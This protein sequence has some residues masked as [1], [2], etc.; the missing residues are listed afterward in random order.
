MYSETL[1]DHFKNPRNAGELE[2]ANVKVE[3]SNLVCGDILHLTAIV[4]E[5]SI[6]E[7]RFLCCGCPAA[8]ACGSLLTESLQGRELSEL[9]SLSPE[10]LAEALGGLPP[11]SYHAAQ[12][13]NDALQALLCE[14]AK[15]AR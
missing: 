3:V 5:K 7:I 9:A 2:A 14:A 4:K 11:A 13:A 1:L 10:S 8:I 12:L 6:R 15:I